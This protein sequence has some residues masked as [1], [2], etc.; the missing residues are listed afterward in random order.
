[1]SFLLLLAPLFLAAAAIA[2]HAFAARPRALAPAPARDCGAGGA[3]GRAACRRSISRWRGR[4]RA[5]C[6]GAASVGLSARLDIVSVAM[7]LTVGFVGWVVLRFSRVALDGEARQSAFMGWMAATIA[8]VLL[9]VGAGNVVPACPGLGGDEPDAAPAAA[10]LSRA[11]RAPGGRPARRRSAASWRAARCWSPAAS[12]GAGFGTSDIAGD[13][14]GGAG[15]R[16]AGAAVAGGPAAGGG[17]RVQVGAGADPRL[18]DRGDGGADAG[19][20]PAACGR[21]ERGRV[22]ADPLRRRAAGGAGRA[23]GAGAGRAASAR[24]SA[25]RWP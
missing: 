10:V 23:G 16:G 11:A 4:R 5:R 3:G 24:W 21:G 15:G 9:L 1:M 20:G 12:C 17:G 25:R 7:T 2:M 6:L 19:L 22:P 14:R 18:A 8:C 13:Q